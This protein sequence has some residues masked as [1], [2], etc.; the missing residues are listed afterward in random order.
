MF[1]KVFSRR[2]FLVGDAFKS[3]VLCTGFPMSSQQ[4]KRTNKIMNEGSIFTNESSQ[5]LYNENNLVHIVKKSF[6]GAQSNQYKEY[7]QRCC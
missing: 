2:S 3:N 1:K 7:L 5:A 4:M 6:R